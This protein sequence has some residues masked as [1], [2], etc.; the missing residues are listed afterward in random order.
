M[1][2]LVELVRAGLGRAV[3]QGRDDVRG[4]HELAISQPG[5]DVVGLAVT[6]ALILG[7]RD[8]EAES[9]TPRAMPDSASASPEATDA[10]RADAAEASSGSA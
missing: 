8:V 3:A 5:R 9:M 10:D 1:H 4:E 6:L 7:I 2:H